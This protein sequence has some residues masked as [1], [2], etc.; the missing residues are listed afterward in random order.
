MG[1]TTA[2]ASSLAQPHRTGLAAAPVGLNAP[3]QSGTFRARP[4]RR[5]TQP[6]PAGPHVVHASGAVLHPA[7]APAS[8]LTGVTRVAAVP[9]LQVPG[10]GYTGA[11]LTSRARA[12]APDTSRGDGDLLSA[13][14]PRPPSSPH[15]RHASM[16]HG[17]ATLSLRLPSRPPT[18]RGSPP[19]LLTPRLRST[20][21]RSF[22][23]SVLCP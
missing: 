1:S 4:V 12:C 20:C 16:A 3:Q 5:C 11:A 17:V 22:R 2:S 15:A 10:G 8:P 21:L 13:T 9:R 14:I 18:R 23:P 6:P 19:S 7:S